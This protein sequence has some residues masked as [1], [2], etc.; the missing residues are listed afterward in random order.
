MSD[1]KNETTDRVARVLYQAGVALSPA[2]VAANLAEFFDDPPS[3]S[4]VGSALDGLDS[5][6]LARR[7][8]AGDVYILTSS[9]RDYVETELDTEAF[10]YVE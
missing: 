10:G 6:G 2:G 1:G 9:G 8:D 7:L 4:A 5:E 3:E